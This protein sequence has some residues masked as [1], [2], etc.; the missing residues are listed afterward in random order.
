MKKKFVLFIFFFVNIL[1][2]G[3]LN[4]LDFIQTYNASSLVQGTKSSLINPAGLYSLRNMNL[5]FNSYNLGLN[6]L[7]IAFPTA[8]FGGN[9][10]LGVY[11]TRV[12]GGFISF[13]NDIWNVLGIGFTLKTLSASIYNPIDG[14]LFDA[15]LI[16]HPNASLG[17]DIF[18]NQFFNDKIF[19]SF[20]VKNIG[21]QPRTTENENLSLRLG[22]GYDL[23]IIGTKFFIEKSFFSDRDVFILGADFSPVINEKRFFSIG[24]SYDLEQRVTKVYGGIIFDS[25]TIN[26]TYSIND[27]MLYLGMSGYFGKKKEE[28]SMEYYNKAFDNYQNALR[29]EKNN[30]EE[31][32]NLY[33]IA[34]KDLVK[35]INL[36]ADN[37][38]AVILK[39]NIEEKIENYKNNFRLEAEKN[40]NNK[41][42]LVALSYYKRLYSI[43]KSKEVKNKIDILS[44]NE[45]VLKSINKEKATL[46]TLYKNKKYVEAKKKANYLVNI[47]P[48]DIEVRN[49][50]SEIENSLEEVAKKYYNIASQE[51]RKGNLTA[52]LDNVRKALYYKPDYSKARDLYNLTVNEITKKKGLENA[53]EEFNKGNNITALK[54]VDA[55]LEKNPDNKEALSLKN[56][57]LQKLKEE[58][59]QILEKGISYYNEGNYEKSIEELDKVLLID[60]TNSIARDYK[61]RA[62]SKL[63]ALKKLEAIEE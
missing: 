56:S 45:N 8:Q 63:K 47:I 59:K 37:K 6:Y 40:E 14:I 26:L 28:L 23:F 39:D 24:L 46:A 50:K 51:Y 13:G 12:A 41:N 32:F 52:C 49:I 31:A 55:Y 9:F 4:D 30:I 20:A 60:S 21:A 54:L 17:L 62:L 27:S 38:K 29:I 11:N 1:S 42:Y 33:Q 19:L 16:F 44:T 18:K 3:E 22:A 35:A 36:D 7:S 48:D 34:N 5:E 58:S 53:R 61:N 15:G 25:L 10:A 43:E 57:I 2:A